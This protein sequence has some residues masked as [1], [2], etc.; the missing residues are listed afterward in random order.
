MT[1]GVASQFVFLVLFALAILY[2]LNEA[3]KGRKMWLRKIPAL[4]AVEEAIGR[5]AEMGKPVLYTP[6]L[7]AVEF[8]ETLA[9]LSF[10]P[11]VAKLTARYNVR[12]IEAQRDQVVYSI[13]E[14]SIRQTYASEGK[15]D[16]FNPTDVRVFPDR[17]GYISGMIGII[18]QEEVAVNLMVGLF[19]AEALIFA[20][21]GN[22]AG[23]LQIAASADQQIPFFVAVCDYTMIGEELYAA[24]AYVSD[25]E[26][27]K[28]II[29]AQDLGKW[30]ISGII[31]IG[32]VLE[33][34]GVDSFTNLMK[35]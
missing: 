7:D 13:A 31:L 24:S 3:K 16:Q 27:Q 22:R 11:Y 4:D 32:A 6:G 9:G 28:G 26:R 14:E 19:R 34:C 25:D 33:T 8:P 20:E 23:A 18:D 29:L 15:I 21:A 10:L 30:L 17:Y 35:M 5:A 12:L 2:Y 1:K